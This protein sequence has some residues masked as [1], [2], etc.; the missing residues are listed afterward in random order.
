MPHLPPESLARRLKSLE[1]VLP[2]F[3][4]CP[5]DALMATVVEE[6][7]EIE[8]DDDFDTA[9]REAVR[10]GRHAENVV[11][12]LIRLAPRRRLLPSE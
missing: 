1:R 3:R 8:A 7:S 11:R 5:D 9:C 12:E 2:F 4:H 6:T 10:R